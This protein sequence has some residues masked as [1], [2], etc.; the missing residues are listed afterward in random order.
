M[1]NLLGNAAVPLSEQIVGPI[2]GSI[3]PFEKIAEKAPIKS[4]VGRLLLN[5]AAGAGAEGVEEILG[6]LFDEMTQYGSDIYADPVI[7]EETG[8]AKT[9]SVG[10]EMRQHDTS[11]QKR[12]KNFFDDAAGNVNSF[13]GG[14]LVDAAMQGPGLP[15]RLKNAAIQDYARHKTG[16]APYVAPKSL[17]NR[18]GFDPEYASLFDNMV[19][20]DEEE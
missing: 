10:R 14:A 6:N 17:E 9:D 8:E 18:E 12:V 3:I 7:D 4:A 13:L 15:F 19:F 2:G 11:A 5:E 20:E 16:V 1:W